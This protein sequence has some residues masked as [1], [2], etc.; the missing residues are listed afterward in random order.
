MRRGCS[1]RDPAEKM[2]RKV[3]DVDR[4]QGRGCRRETWRQKIEGILV[5]ESQHIY[6]IQDLGFGLN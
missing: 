3:W 1:T 4:S 2:K 5:I 6:D